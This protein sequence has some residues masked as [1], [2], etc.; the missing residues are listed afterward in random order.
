MKPV[1]SRSKQKNGASF[2]FLYNNWAIWGTVTRKGVISMR[3]VEEMY[4]FYKDQLTGDED[5]A[6]AVVLGILQDQER[7]DL[8]KLIREM[9]EQELFHMMAIYMVEMLRM[10]M[11]R[12]EGGAPDNVSKLH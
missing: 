12:D 8:M 5:D 3:F 6:I 9:D 1:G 2:F 10:K 7:D 11:E 4:Q